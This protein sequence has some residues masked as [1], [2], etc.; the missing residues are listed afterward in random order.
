MV[1]IDTSGIG[2]LGYR[3]ADGVGHV[4]KRPTKIKCYTIY[5][6]IFINRTNAQFPTS[7]YG[8]YCQL[9]LLIHSLPVY[10]GFSRHE[11]TNHGA[12]SPYSGWAALAGP[13]RGIL[14]V[15]HC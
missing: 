13:L 2:G 3:P 1:G 9:G 7:R 14:L 6:Y 4:P 15:E 8:C 11:G 10:L 12:P 5:R